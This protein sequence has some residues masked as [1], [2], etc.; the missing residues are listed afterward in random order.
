MGKVL[1]VLR[2]FLEGTRI[3]RSE[4]TFLLDAGVLVTMW[5][6]CNCILGKKEI[7]QHREV[8]HPCYW[9]LLG[10]SCGSGPH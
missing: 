5:M 3:S 10:C 9:W 2:K 7:K 1:S 6:C 4:C 8:V